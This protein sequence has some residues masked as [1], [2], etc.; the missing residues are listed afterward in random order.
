[1][2]HTKNVTEA[3]IL[4]Q[5]QT[6][7]HSEQSIALI[8]KAMDFATRMHEGQLRKSGEP[9]IIHAYQV[10]YIL[11]QLETGPSTICAGLLHDVLED[12][13]CTR[14]YMVEEFGE[15]ITYL[16]ESVTKVGNLK[17]ADEKEYQ[18]TNHRKIFIAMAKDVRVILI[19]LVD[20]LH[21]MRTL[22]FQPEHKQK[23][24]A[25]ETMAVYAPIA[26]RL[27]ISDIKNELEDL[28]FYYLNREKYYEIAHLVD[29]KQSERN[30]QVNQ[31][32]ENIKGYLEVE[33]IEARIFGRSKHLYSIYKKMITKNKRFD[34]ILDLLAIR[35]VTKTETNCYE[36]LGIIHAAY[37]PI[38]GRFKD[39]IA[40]PKMNMYQSLHTT[41]VGEEGNIFEVQIRTEEM[42]SIAEKGVAAHWSYKEGK[43]LPSKE[44]QKEIE[45]KLAWFREIININEDESDAVDYMN[46]LKRDIFEA[47]VYVMSPMGRVI[48]LPNGATPL[49]FAY[50]I[51]TD[52]GHQTVGATVNGVLV[53]L[54][55]PLK[56]GDVV[57]IRTSKQN[58][59]PSEDWL[60][61]VK[62]NQAKN[63]I[64]SY[65]AKKDAEQKS[66]FVEKGEEML[67]AELRKRG[68]DEKEY[69]DSKKLEA[70]FNQVAVS[71]YMD[72]MYAIAVKSLSTQAVIEKLISAPQQKKPLD[73]ESISKYYEERLQTMHKKKISKSGI[74]VHGVDSMM[75]EI[76]GCCSPI[77]GDDI[78]GYIT[79]GKGV[80]VHRRDCPNVVNE[81]ARLID[82]EWDENYIGNEKYRADLLITATDRNL[83]LSDII[84]MLGQC[85][86]N[87]QSVNGQIA[88]DKIN[89]IFKLTITVDNLSHLEATIVNLKKVESVVDVQRVI[90]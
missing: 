82:V 61:I 49:D 8:K 77:P 55:T 40:M 90:H 9:Y 18:A 62:T 78:V 87:I 74:V 56:T 70:I 71:N 22:E 53:P 5:V 81:K 52:V 36:I 28:C 27:G 68:Y 16:V 13:D 3:D 38:P 57:N 50:R 39:Y 10:G 26:H 80:K 65:L 73:N 79:K 59:G 42:D 2:K 4:A 41:I 85:K 43:S 24:I 30:A 6:Y 46:S 72:F 17:F 32:I 21:N 19:K 12:C 11:S 14:E 34:E 37:K 76:S 25:E 1:M 60:K 48:D 31:M 44:E 63:K 66:K 67:A 20:R 89:A 69:M 54:N 7:I 51:H 23:K 45:D 86:T 83:L 33:G 88:D 47:N 84:T 29:K 35:I 75:I 15:E 58:N 64:R